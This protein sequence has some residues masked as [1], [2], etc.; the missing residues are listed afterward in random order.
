MAEYRLTFARSAA[1]ELEKFDPP[2]ARRILAA[3]EKLS[4]A[5]RPPGCI[6]LTGSL[7]D[8]RIRI[9]DWRVIYSV[10]DK[11]SVVDIVAVR[12]RGDAYR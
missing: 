7:N 10:S 3:I 2:V 12:H 11:D 8:W 6:K 9:G 5:P 1:R 4:H